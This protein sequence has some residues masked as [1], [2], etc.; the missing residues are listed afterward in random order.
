MQTGRHDG[1]VVIYRDTVFRGCLDDLAVMAHT[2]LAFVP[3][4]TVLRAD[5]RRHITGL[6]GMNAMRLMVGVGFVQHVLIIGCV[7][8]G[9]VMTDNLHAQAV[10]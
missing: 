7:S 4:Q 8:T 5:D 3:L 10:G 6:D 2:R 1:F 9:L